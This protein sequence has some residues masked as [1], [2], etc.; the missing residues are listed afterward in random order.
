MVNQSGRARKKKQKLLLAKY[1]ET[2]KKLSEAE[3]SM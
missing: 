3:K 1:K 2:I